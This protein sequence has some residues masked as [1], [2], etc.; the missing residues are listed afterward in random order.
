MKSTSWFDL[1]T[2]PIQI[3]DREYPETIEAS[4]KRVHGEID[5]LVEE[6]I[7]SERIVIGGFSQGG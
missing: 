6:G 5:K 7:A 4:M 1:D 3:G 2:I